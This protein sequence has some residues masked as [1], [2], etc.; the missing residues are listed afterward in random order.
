[1]GRVEVLAIVA[2]VSLAGGCGGPTALP[3]EAELPIGPNQDCGCLLDAQCVVIEAESG[4]TQLRNVSCRWIEPGETAR[5][6]YESRRVD[7]ERPEG[8]ESDDRGGRVVELAPW[9]GGAVTA[10]RFRGG[11]CAG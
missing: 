6:T 2:A 10:R 5:C 11:W 4:W 8:Y 1:M 3:S 7:H 9:R